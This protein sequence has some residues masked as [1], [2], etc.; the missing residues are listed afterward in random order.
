MNIILIF[1]NE[2]ENNGLARISGER[3]E[4]IRNVLKCS[5]GDRL[6]IGIVDGPLGEGVLESIGADAVV[7][8]CRFE[9]DP[10]PMPRIDLL[11]AMPRPKVMARLWSRLAA[12]GV[13]RLVLLKT[14]KVE[15]SFFTSHI[16]RP[17]NYR[18]RLIDGLQQAACTHMPEVLLR[19][20]F[21]PFL[22]DELDSVFA[23]SFRI[24]ARPGAKIALLDLLAG[25]DFEAVSTDPSRRILLAIGPEGGWEEY[26][27]EKLEKHG[28]RRAAMGQRILQSDAACILALGT[29]HQAL[30]A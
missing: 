6:R 27:I 7:L 17:E 9:S 13:G 28:F 29:V 22:E 26:E 25:P 14:S 10:P 30:R 2:L 15:K 23:D 4:H 12:V 1:R 5:C 21:K 20:R 16:L 18:A 8:N 11:L 24:L 19:P 3:A